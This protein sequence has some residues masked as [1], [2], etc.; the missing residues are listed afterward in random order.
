MLAAERSAAA[1]ERTAAASERAAVAAERSASA[2]EEVAKCLNLA[3]VEMSSV[4]DTL[5]VIRKI[6]VD[7]AAAY[8]REAKC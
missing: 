1:A 7:S 6:V 8:G 2:H 4:D 5:D 3:A